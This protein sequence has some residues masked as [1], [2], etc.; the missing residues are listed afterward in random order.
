LA[1]AVLVVVVAS[2]RSLKSTEGLRSVVVVVVAEELSSLRSR[3][4]AREA[5]ATV[6]TSPSAAVTFRRTAC[7]TSQERQVE[8]KLRK[9]KGPREDRIVLLVLLLLAVSEE[10][11]EHNREQKDVDGVV[12]PRALW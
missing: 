6:A 8:G 2:S 11:W 4:N 3:V 1:G 7:W 12:W 10:S 9:A 5:R